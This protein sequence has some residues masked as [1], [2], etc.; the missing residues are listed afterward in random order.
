MT[1][2][3]SENAKNILPI[4]GLF[5]MSVLKFVKQV[6]N[7]EIHHTIGFEPREN[8]YNLRNVSSTIRFKTA[9]TDLGQRQILFY[10]PRVYNM[11]T[12][13]T[14]AIRS[15]YHFLKATKLEISSMSWIEKYLSLTKI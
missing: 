11:L 2:Y 13:N 3:T 6:F 1:L 12:E 7:S 15:T 9:R 4:K 14:R 10:G 8:I 5:L